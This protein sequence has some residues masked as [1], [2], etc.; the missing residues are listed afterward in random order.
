MALPAGVAPAAPPLPGLNGE[1]DRAAVDVAQPPWNA[2]LR[3]QTNLGGRCTGALVG[4]R[5]VLTA[6]H[7]LFNARTG[8]LLPPSSLHVLF[9]YERGRYAAH[10][11]V[12]RAVAGPGYDGRRA[13]ASAGADWALLTLASAAPDGVRPFPIL[14]SAVEAGTAAVL[15]GYSQDRTHVLMADRDCR[16]TGV[17]TPPG[18]ALLR[19]DC[20]ATRGTSGGPLLVRDGNGWAV[21]GV[22]VAAT[23]GGNIAVAAAAFAGAVE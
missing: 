22:S 10:R 7:C 4:P 3:V 18:P 21:A 13:G 17:S 20:A 9:G 12:D 11:L 15:A 5:L 2:V 19:H 14:P 16:V 23:A 8:R 6:A 1:D